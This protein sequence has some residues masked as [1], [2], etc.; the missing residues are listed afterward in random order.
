MRVLAT[1][2]GSAAFATASLA[3]A[4]VPLGITV[5]GNPVTSAQ[6]VEFKKS[7][8][9]TPRFVTFFVAWPAS[10]KDL[11][12]P[13]E[14]LRA[15]REQGAVPVITWEPWTQSGETMN[16]IPEA[17]ILDGK[18]DA[19]LRAFAEAARTDGQPIWI[20]FAH[21]MNASHYHWGF[22]SD[23]EFGPDAP[24][25][26][27]RIHRHVVDAFRAANASNVSW[28]FCPN[29]ES[30]P[31]PD[32]DSNA[33][34]NRVDRYYPGDDYVD[35]MGMDG[36]NWGTS[37]TPEANGWQSH[38]QTFAGIFE[39]LH[40]TLTRIAP[41]KPILVFETATSDSGGDKAAWIADALQTASDW[42]LSGLSWFDV[43]KEVDWRLERNIPRDITKSMQ[44]QNSP[45]DP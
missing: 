44:D 7:S 25:A 26:F 13:A 20:R 18:W 39:P 40:A 19:Y 41:S 32:H 5:E 22:K 31:N 28:V 16:V 35:L 21:E 3:K 17:E 36:Y 30:V 29:A 27:R 8:G 12:F 15:I 38:W 42:K 33:K 34:W 37:R 11:N 14:S 9:I 24:F 2:A 45:L 43:N 4:G 10:P 6:L 23:A 1:I